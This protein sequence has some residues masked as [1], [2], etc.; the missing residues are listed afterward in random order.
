MILNQP[1]LNYLN[2]YIS[3]SVNNNKT[4]YKVIIGN[5]EN[6]DEARKDAIK[7]RNIFNN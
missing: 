5:Y 7:I 4:D 6:L 1:S 3:K 2:G